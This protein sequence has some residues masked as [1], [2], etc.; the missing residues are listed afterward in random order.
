M[1]WEQLEKAASIDRLRL[2]RTKGAVTVYTTDAFETPLMSIM[3]GDLDD[4]EG[5]LVLRQ[6]LERG[7]RALK[8]LPH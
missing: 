3:I 8:E 4:K 1:T 6:T 2:L 7:L 5:D